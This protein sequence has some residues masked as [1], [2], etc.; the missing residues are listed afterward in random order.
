MTFGLYRH[1][2]ASPAT[3]AAIGSIRRRMP[4]PVATNPDRPEL[5]TVSEVALL[6]RCSDENVRRKIRSGQ[7]PGFHVGSPGS[8]IR[9]PRAELVAWLRGSWGPRP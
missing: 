3:A 5:L 9:I 8:A 7:L 2:S 6:L 4:A 1:G